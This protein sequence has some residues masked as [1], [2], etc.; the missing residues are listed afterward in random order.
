MHPG[1]NMRNEA[2]SRP[3]PWPGIARGPEWMTALP[4]HVYLHELGRGAHKSVH[5]LWDATLQ[6]HVAVSAY[7]LTTDEVQLW[8][9]EART[10]SSWPTSAWRNRRPAGRRTSGRRPAPGRNRYQFAPWANSA[11]SSSSGVSISRSSQR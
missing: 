10:R 9:T 7:R 6:Q 1:I 3:P 5:L 11:F 4:D 8:L 2:D